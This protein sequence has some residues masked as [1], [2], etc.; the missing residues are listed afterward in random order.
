MTKDYY[1]IL[2]INK[3]ADAGVIKKAYR[4]LANKYHPDK[5]GGDETKFKE[6][7]EAY[8]ILSDST[9]RGQYD[10]PAFNRARG[11]SQGGSNFDF[12]MGDVSDIFESFFGHPWDT[13]GRKPFNK[14]AF[15]KQANKGPDIRVQ[16]TLTFMESFN[17]VT[18]ILDVE[19]ERTRINISPGIKTGQSLRIKGKGAHSR[20]GGLRGDII[21]SVDVAADFKWLTRGDDIYMDINVP[22]WD[23]LLGCEMY[24]ETPLKEIK[25]KI[26]Q[27]S[28]TGQLLRIKGSGMPVYNHDSLYG[29][30]MVKL[31]ALFPTNL[32]TRQR[33]LLKQLKLN[34]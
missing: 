14:D 6:V 10:S 22:L 8:S 7:A 34:Q 4:K 32:T 5:P 11:T 28:K 31:N 30:L 33:D 15:N 12:N 20:Y 19:G 29:N 9:K 23:M 3:S 27:A 1:H 25:I 26:P 16:M 17:G 2:G 21:I 13:E 24:V 18:K